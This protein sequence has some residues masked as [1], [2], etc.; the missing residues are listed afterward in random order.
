MQ[1]KNVEDKW[2]MLPYAEAKEGDYLIIYH[3]DLPFPKS[4]MKAYF[5]FHYLKPWLDKF[6]Y[7]APW[8]INYEGQE[9]GLG[10]YT[11]DIGYSFFSKS[12]EERLAEGKRTREN[13]EK[14]FQWHMS[15]KKWEEYFDSVKLEPVER[16]WASQPK[17]HKPV[18]KPQDIPDSLNSNNIARWL[19]LNV[20]GDPSK[21]NTFF[22]ARLTRDL[23]YRS[24]T[25]STGGMYFNESSAAFD[26]I[27]HRVEFN[28]DIAYDQMVGMCERKNSWEQKRIETMKHRGL[29]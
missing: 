19:I 15:G 29:M 21:I 22:E 20:L 11:P 5:C 25:S 23:L 3:E 14:H 4:I 1:G 13:F 7:I 6:E 18:E 2:D 17:I 9:Y 12:E 28:F 26:G 24:A 8:K 27:N 16:T 10:L